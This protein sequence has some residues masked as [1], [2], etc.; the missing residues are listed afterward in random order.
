MRFWRNLHE[1]WRG[2][3]ESHEDTGDMTKAAIF[4]IS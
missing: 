2:D 3:A 1:I 4:K